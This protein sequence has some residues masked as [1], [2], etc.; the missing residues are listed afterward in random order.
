MNVAVKTLLATLDEHPVDRSRIYLTGLSMGGYGSWDLAV[1]HP[2]W[3]AAIAPICGGGDV[4]LAH[5]LALTPLWAYHGDADT[6]VPVKRS[7][8]M[9]GAI[10]HAGGL[11]RYWGK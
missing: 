1:R 9:V 2:D 4:D 3:F 8:D 6:A 5:R 11:P 7:R 10:R